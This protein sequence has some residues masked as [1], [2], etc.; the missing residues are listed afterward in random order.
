MVL[1]TPTQICDV[2]TAS[3]PQNCLPSGRLGYTY[4]TPIR[5]CNGFICCILNT[6]MICCQDF[7]ARDAAIN[8]TEGCDSTES[9]IE[10]P[11]ALPW[12]SLHQL[13]RA[14]GDMNSG[15]LISAAAGS[16]SSEL[17]GSRGSGGPPPRIC[18]GQS[19]S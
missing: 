10:R 14:M 1:E 2:Q 4:T 11:P 3:A 12:D 9:V 15:N 18:T 8:P 13:F 16:P 6:C 19:V 17:S 7:M 5:W